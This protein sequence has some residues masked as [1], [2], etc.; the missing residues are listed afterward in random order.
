VTARPPT[1][2]PGSKKRVQRMSFRGN[3]PAEMWIV[4]VVLLFT[5]FVVGPWIIRR[6]PP[7]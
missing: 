5:L 4:V 3:W 6:V 2:Y 7:V 1:I